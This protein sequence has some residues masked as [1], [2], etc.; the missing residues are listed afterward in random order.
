VPSLTGFH[1]FPL[2]TFLSNFK[3]SVTF[4]A[5]VQSKIISDKLPMRTLIVRYVIMSQIN[6][7]LSG[8]TCDSCI[9]SV[10][11]ILRSLDSVQDVKVELTRAIITAKDSSQ[12]TVREMIAAITEIGYE[13]THGE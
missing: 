12:T 1:S 10:T 8:L 3:K 5:V 11:G 2:K 13:A 7:K 6:L 9:R 4:V